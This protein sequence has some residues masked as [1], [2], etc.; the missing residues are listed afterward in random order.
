MSF[1]VMLTAGEA[2]GDL[3]GAHLARALLALDP[4]IQV[5]GIGGWRMAEAGVELMYRSEDLACMGVVEVGTRFLTIRRIFQGAVTLLKERRPHLLIPI[6]YP[7][8]NLR[9]SGMARSVGI[10]VLYYVSPKV[11]AWGKWR[12]RRIVSS[13]SKLIVVLPFEVDVYRGYPIE[14]IYP[15]HPLVDIV[16]TDVSP[17]VFRRWLEMTS[18]RPFVGLLPGSRRQEVVRIL[19]TMLKTVALMEREVGKLHVVVGCVADVEREVYTRIVEREAIQA[20]MV[21]GRTYDLMAASDLLFAASG[22]V[23]LEAAILG[24]P[25]VVLYRMAPLSY[26]LARLV[27]DVPSVSLPNLIAE[28]KIVPECLQGEMV[29]ERVG[30][31]G[32]RLL[33]EISERRRMIDDLADVKG[34]LGSGGVSR[35]I[36]E[37]ATLMV[38][39]RRLHDLPV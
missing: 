11:W 6:D 36:A 30:A 25:M 9:L 21:E 1:S 23:T 3:Y 13:V 39:E 5:F 10:P 16:R 27:V 7:G 38:H 14:V 34:R 17:D 29:P 8:F 15:G 35:K 12:I 26:A 37:I 20:L 28:R 32:L 31:W 4:S 19:P 22:T 24:I 33:N 18:D 2:S